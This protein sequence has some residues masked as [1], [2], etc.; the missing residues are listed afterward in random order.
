MYGYIVRRLAALVL[1]LLLVSIS[2]FIVMRV[3]PG[4]PAQIILGTQ[5]TEDSLEQVREKLGLNQPL[6]HQYLDWLKG[7]VTGDFQYSVHYEMPVSKL[8]ISRMPVSGPL[9]ILAI[10][11]TIVLAIPSGVYAATHHNRAGDY[12]TMVLSQL[13]ISIPEF[14]LGILLIL[15]FAVNLRWFAAGGFVSWSVSVLGA[16]KS[17]LLPALSLAVGRAAITCRMT[18]SAML[19][20]LGEDYIR[21]ARSKG[22]IERTVIYKHALRN[23]LITIITVIGM[24][25]GQLLAGEMIVE[26]VFLL[27]GLGRLALIAILKRDLPVVQAIVLLVAGV[28][29]ITNFGVDLLYGVMDPRVRYE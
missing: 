8:I 17:L 11:I 23:S 20:I 21:T 19:E 10:L 26:N 29:V 22:L 9:A 12:G 7:A 24:Q 25:L 13:G 16:L 28:I 3:L 1:T 27:P 18:R 4:D 14:W 15:L 5:A 2:I 6:I